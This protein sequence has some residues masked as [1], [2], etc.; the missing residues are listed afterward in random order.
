MITATH[1]SKHYGSV[2]AV[3]DISFEVGEG[4]H[5]VLLGTS[6]CGKTTTL[7]MI[8][9][10]IAPG[11]GHITVNGVDINEQ[12]PEALR[13]GIG[14]VL[15]HNSLFPHY[16]VAENI[17]VVPKLLQWNKKKIQQRTEELLHKLNLP[18]AK[19][20]NTYPHQLSGGQQQR[21][22]IARALAADPP[23]LLMDEPFGALDTITRS[24]I[25]KEFSEL[26]EF[27]RKTIVMVTHDVQEAFLLGDRICLMNEGRIA[28][29]G[30][31]AELLFAPANDFVRE[32]LSAS[33]LRLALGAVRVKDVW[34]NINGANDVDDTSF[35]MDAEDSLWRVMEHA[36][37]NKD[38]KTVT[39]RN[40]EGLVKNV[41]QEELFKAFYKHG[42]FPAF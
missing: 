33:Y 14:Y 31:P 40:N 12:S 38:S 35:V 19:Y 18:P 42:H 16:T 3:D 17:A 20:L 9:R 4:E 10:L 27:T 41:G 23:I 6:G 26:D 13:R 24:S 5:L 7:K 34:A 29:I 28:Q 1:L 36:I 15:Q 25:T 30:K 2:T 37:K 11:G 8:N 39:I 32:F 22:N 21:V